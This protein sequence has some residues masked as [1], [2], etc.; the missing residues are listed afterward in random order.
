VPYGFIFVRNCNGSHHPEEHMDLDDFLKA[1][2]VL[3]AWLKDHA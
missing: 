3:S 1:T 2:A